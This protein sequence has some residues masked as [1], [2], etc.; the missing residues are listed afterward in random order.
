[1]C[2]SVLRSTSSSVRSVAYRMPTYYYGPCAT[3]NHHSICVKGGVWIKDF[4][5]SYA[6]VTIAS[7]EEYVLYLPLLNGPTITV[8]G[9]DVDCLYVVAF[10]ATI[11]KNV[12]V[13]V[14]VSQSVCL[15]HNSK[16]MKPISLKCIKHTRGT[17]RECGSENW[18]FWII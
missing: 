7:A 12:C 10:N 16:T 1:M 5:K 13:S 3:L 6:A 2:L 15:F 18:V 9:I 8:N 14:S 4:P 17:P 11:I